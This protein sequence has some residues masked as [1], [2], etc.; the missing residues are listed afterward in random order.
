MLTA[1]E[2]ELAI[3]CLEIYIGDYPIEK[4]YASSIILKMLFRERFKELMTEVREATG[5][6]VNNRQDSKVITWGK[7]IRKVGKCHICGSDKKLEAHHIV[8][9]E[10]SIKGRTDINNGICLCKKCH[11]MMHNTGEYM[12]YLMRGRK[13]E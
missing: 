2:T 9:W 10:Y 5:F 6:K 12:D 4:Q 3:R 8:P 11:K 13:N 1:K 7:K